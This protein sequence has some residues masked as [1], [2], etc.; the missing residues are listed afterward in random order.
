MS[1]KLSRRSSSSGTPDKPENPT[2]NSFEADGAPERSAAQFVPIEL[3]SIPESQPRRYFDQAG[4]QQLT[5]SVKEH[6]IL[7][8]IIVRPVGEK[9]EIVA[10]ERRYR[11]AIEAG[12]TE[13]P[14]L[15]REMSDEQAVQYALVENLQ[16]ED[17]TPIEEVEGI[18][19]LLALKLKTDRDGAISLLNQMANVKRGFTDNV[20]RNEEQQIVEEVFDTIGRLSPESFRTH[21]LPLLNLPADILEALR[22]GQIEYTKAKEIAK[23]ESESERMALLQEAMTRSLSLSQIRERVKAKKPAVERDSLETRLEEIYQKAKKLK[24]WR[25]PEKREKLESL[26]AAMEALLSGED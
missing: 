26:L 11:A 16:R 20:V 10:G 23:L 3:I 7:Q 2:Q 19:Q 18:L 12:L 21:R 15:V 9:Y 8:P 25:N 1:P 17:L 22:T 14:A 6:G 4:M 24:V 13:V 5:A